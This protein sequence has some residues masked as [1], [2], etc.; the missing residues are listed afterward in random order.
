VAEYEPALAS[1]LASTL[2]FPVYML[3]REQLTLHH[4]HYDKFNNGR[5]VWCRKASSTAE[6]V[7]EVDVWRLWK[8]TKRWPARFSTCGSC[9]PNVYWMVH[10]EN[11]ESS[12]VLSVTA[13]V[14]L[15]ADYFADD[16]CVRR[17]KNQWG[18]RG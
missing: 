9:N 14:L 2:V 3:S 10:P 1:H 5:L 18:H 11:C 12:V 8:D 13:R 16:A 17:Y 6:V 4:A 7:N 15:D